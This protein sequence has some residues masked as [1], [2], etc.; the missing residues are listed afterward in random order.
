MATA[1]PRQHDQAAQ[2]IGRILGAV[3]LVL[4]GLLLLAL[5]ALTA[6]NTDPGRAFVARQLARIAPESGLTVAV[7]RIEGSLYGR[8]LIR[9]LRVGDPNGVFATAPLVVLDWHPSSLV[10]RHVDVDELSAPTVRVLRLPELRPTPPTDEPILPDIDISVDRLAVDRIILEPPVAGSRQ[11]ASLTGKADIADGRAIVTANAASTAGDRL[12]LLLDA[13]PDGDRFDIDATLTAPVGGVVDRLAGLGR[14]L[15]ASIEGQG[16][17]SD[18]RGRAR[19]QVA[20][21]PLVDLQLSGRDGTFTARGEARP[22]ILFPGLPARVLGPVLAID[23]VAILAERRADTRLRLT[24]AAL[25]LSARGLI[26]LANS[27][28]GNFDIETQLLRSA[29]LLD[30]AKGRDVRLHLGLN[31]PFATPTVDYRLTAAAL[32]FG[33]TGIEQLQATGRATLARTGPILVPVAATA[34]RVTGV[35]EVVGG[36]LRNLRVDGTL[37]VTPEQLLSDNLRLRS[38]RLQATAVLAASFRTGRYDLALKGTLNR[39]ELPGLGLIDLRTDA[40]LAPLAAGGFGVRANVEARVRRL[41]NAGLRSFLGGLPTIRAAVERTAD[42]AIRFTNLQVQAP[43]LRI[44]NARGVYRPDGTLTLD[45]RGQ[46]TSYGPFTVSADGPATR[47]RIRL[48]AARPNVGVQLTG[49]EALLTP[50]RAG[51]AI[52]ASGGSPYGPFSAR[53]RVALGGRLTAD[54]DSL[55]IM[56]LNAQGRVVQTAAGPFAGRIAISGSGISGSAVLAAAGRVQRVDAQ[57]RADQARLALAEPVLIAQGTANATLLLVPGAPSIDG[58]LSVRGLRRGPLA[59]TSLD[60][61]GSYRAGRGSAQVRAAGENGVPFDL[62]ADAGFAPDRIR[63]AASGSANR[64]AL[65]FERPVE[66]VPAP[67]GWRLLPATLLLPSGRAEIA[68]TFGRNSSLSARLVNVDLAIARAF[69]RQLRLGGRLSGTVSALLPA[70]GTPQADIG[71]AVLGLTRSSLASTSQPIDVGLNAA[72]RTGGASMRAVLRRGTEIV[73]RAQ[74]RLAPLGRGASLADRFLSA[75][76]SGGFRYNG[77]AEALWALSGMTGHEVRGP[78]VIAADF[79]GRVDD[80]RLSGV[81]RAQ[82]LR[83]DNLAFGTVI[84]NIALDSRFTGPR[85]ELLSL[86]ATTGRSGSL[87]ASGTADLSAARGFPADIRA[88]LRGARLARRD[89]MSAAVSGSGRLTNGRTGGLVSGDLRIDSARY[90]IGRRSAVADIPT[91]AVRRVP[92][93]GAVPP[94]PAPSTPAP[95]SV[96]RLDV[97]ARANN[98]I[99]VEGMGLES[100]WRSNLRVRGTATVPQITGTVDLL[101]GTFSFAGRR[102]DLTRGRVTFTGAN[103]PDPAVDIVAE[104]TVDGLSATITVTG[105]GQQPQISFTSIPSL[106]QEEVLSRLL[107][108]ESVA[109]LS[110]VQA[111]Q[112]ATSV[113]SLR[114]GSGGG[115]NPIGKLRQA[116]G[117]DRF[118]ILGADRQEGRGTAL[119]VGE[120]LGDNVYVEVTTDVRG[121]TATQLE[122]A[123]SRALSIITQVGGA[124]GTNVGIRYGKDY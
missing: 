70:G 121:F 63:V 86:T 19:A 6:L 92:Q 38:D 102:F 72:L 107:F 109:E 59:L 67:G 58:R 101:R 24:S 55:R 89:D 23:A 69:S 4:L 49:V 79:G 85:F 48:R 53:V 50:T 5:L 1:A 93:P 115:L 42:G 22:G 124:G 97:R 82:G 95:P 16:G 60:G 111:L 119:A 15:Q 98:E 114:G 66:L 2:T 27:R 110:A 37:R 30:G 62:A 44:T 11:I 46:S 120:H 57:L 3:A 8:L 18:W 12:R 26:D 75:G 122:I 17:W 35:N 84:D 33:E 61:Q 91:L 45:A 99:R 32:G 64:I 94:R 76:L 87:S 105:T 28:F 77:P 21:A 43:L 31:G 65:R 106:P 25:D 74:A 100:E 68:G 40:T 112:L 90:N 113:A 88:E 80:P 7:G 14:P 20:A 29:A 104:T 47:P 81:V 71:L 108:G 34:T 83:Y 39:Y 118:R 103:P 117:V 96:V 9:D 10:R 51:Y 78:L 41:D 123:L 56:G 54:I 73:G 52:A 36:L 116:T 13:V